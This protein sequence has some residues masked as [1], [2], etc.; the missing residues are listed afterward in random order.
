MNMSEPVNNFLDTSQQLEVHIEKSR[1][2]CKN[3]LGDHRPPTQGE[4]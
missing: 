2:K 1:E 4:E 3:D